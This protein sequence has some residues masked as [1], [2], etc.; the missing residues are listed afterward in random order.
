[1]RRVNDVVFEA[2][3]M[4][5]RFLGF[6]FLNPGYARESLEEIQRCVVDGGM[7]GIKLYHQYF[8][9]DPAQRPVMDRAAELQVPVLMH[10]GK[11]TDS[12]T[13]ASQPRLSNAS[14]FAKAAQMFPETIFIQGHIGGGGGRYP[15]LF[16]ESSRIGIGGLPAAVAA[17]RVLFGTG[18][19][20]KCVTPSLLKLENA[21]L[22]AASRTRVAGQTAR[23]L[24][25]LR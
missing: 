10:A 13:R 6:C 15:N 19:P 5:P 24:L 7:L 18:A 12:V 11:C 16:L 21:D 17:K 2:M 4:S 20:F 23:R 8:I 9:C 14:H 25:G 1:V 22:D 3:A